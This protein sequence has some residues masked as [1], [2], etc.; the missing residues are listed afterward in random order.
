MEQKQRRRL[1]VYTAGVV[2]LTTM[3]LATLLLNDTVYT[4][5]DPAGL[6][7]SLFRNLLA[8]VVGEN[9]VSPASPRIA[10]YVAHFAVMI[11]AVFLIVS[12]RK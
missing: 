9:N 10:H 4:F 1:R 7:D 3:I 8:A 6:G 2:L 11:F 12:S 5:V